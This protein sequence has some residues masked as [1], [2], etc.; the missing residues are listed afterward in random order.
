[1]IKF[2]QALDAE[3]RAAGLKITALCPGFTSTE[4]AD[5]NGTS[6]ALKA[7]PVSCSTARQVVDAALAANDEGRVVV[8]PAGIRRSPPR[9]CNICRRPGAPHADARLG[10]LSP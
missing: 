5:A 1:M 8:C 9:R 6:D 2:S 4:F 7:A 10:A 3:Y